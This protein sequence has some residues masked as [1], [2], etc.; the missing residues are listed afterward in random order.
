M[1]FINWFVSE[2]APSKEV[3]DL[4]SDNEWEGEKDEEGEEA[5]SSD[6]EQVRFI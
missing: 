1:I 2:A 4:G 6:E 3:I 5:V